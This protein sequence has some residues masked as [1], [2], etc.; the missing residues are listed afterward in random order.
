MKILMLSEYFY[1]FDIGGSEWSL[2]Y[3]SEGL[4][5][6]G[7]DVTILTPNYGGAPKEEFIKGFKVIRFPFYLK[8]KSKNPISPFWHTNILWLIWT[9]FYLLKYLHESKT[10]LIHVQGKYFLP[11]AVITKFLTGKKI[12]VTL[13]DYIILCPLGLCLQSSS[14][15]CNFGYFISKEIKEYLNIYMV[16]KSKLRKTGVAI[17]A[18]RAKFASLT[19]KFLL[20]FA[21]ETVA[22]SNLEKDIYQ[23]N[24]FKN[25]KVIPNP[26]TYKINDSKRTNTIIFAGRLTPG[27][28]P[29]LLLKSMARVFKKYPGYRLWIFGNGF[30]RQKL[31]DLTA[32]LK[33]TGNVIFKGHVEHKMLLKKI[34]QSKLTIMPSVWPEP[35]GRVA[36]ESVLLGTPA[37]VT[38]NTGISQYLN[39]SGWGLVARPDVADLAEKTILMLK[40]I[41][42]F[43]RKI[44]TDEAKIQNLFSEAVYKSHLAL[45]EKYNKQQN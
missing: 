44:K 29:D 10:E 13:R 45:Y 32:D 3:L 14:K 42:E 18:L 43:S 36:L 6:K 35:F 19:L 30:L 5:K 2:Y 40:D 11:S 28:G 39:N 21:N 12:I 25:I 26:F 24:G 22:I 17:F 8:M 23:K 34:S 15:S 33:I 31:E 4:V 37:V 38:E 16:Q 41:S 20:K 7:V 1:P 9:T 27:K